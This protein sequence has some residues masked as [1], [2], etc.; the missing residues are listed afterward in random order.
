MANDI[1]RSEFCYLLSKKTYHSVS[2]GHLWFSIFSRPPSTRFTRIQ[3]CT[4]CFVLL[5]S[6]MLLNILYYQSSIDGKQRSKNSL[7]I[8][9]MNVS[10]EQVCSL[11]FRVLIIL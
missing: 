3:R 6:S 5:F 2:D 10:S 11:R 1:E 7:A 8:G 9:S 4:C